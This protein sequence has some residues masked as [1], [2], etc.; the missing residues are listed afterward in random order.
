MNAEQRF[1]NRF[2]PTTPNRAF[3]NLRN[4]AL[5]NDSITID[6]DNPCY[7]HRQHHHTETP[8][9]ITIQIKCTNC[10][11]TNHLVITRPQVLHI[12]TQRRSS[13]S[14]S[15][16]SLSSLSSS[17]TNWTSKTKSQLNTK[18]PLSLIN[19]TTLPLKLPR[20]TKLPKNLNKRKVRKDFI[21]PTAQNSMEPL[22]PQK[23]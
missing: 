6:Y 7:R 17:S 11:H 5:Q 16:S 22:P 14:S 9:P 15:S 18:Y 12:S 10:N 3:Q 13:S 1:N 23:K 2:F 20:K 4:R 19:K 21:F 8:A